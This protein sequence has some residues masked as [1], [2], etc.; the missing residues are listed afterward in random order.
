MLAWIWRA[1][2]WTVGILV[3]LAALTWLFFWVQDMS[4]IARLG[5]AILAFLTFATYQILERLNK[6]GERV[7][8][9]HRRLDGRS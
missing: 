5:Y 7:E 1:F 6:I 9:L 3:G 2:L 4:E 8:E